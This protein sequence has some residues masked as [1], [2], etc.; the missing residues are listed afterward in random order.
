ML[1][2][3]CLS[4]LTNRKGPAR[5]QYQLRALIAQKMALLVLDGVTKGLDSLL[6]VTKALEM[7]MKMKEK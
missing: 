1:T 5:S 2:L 6:M 7:K 3:A 4:S